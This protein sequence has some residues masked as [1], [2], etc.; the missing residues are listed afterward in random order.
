MRTFYL[1]LIFCLQSISYSVNS[2][3][4]LVVSFDG[5]RYDYIDRNITPNLHMLKSKSTSARFLVNIFPT[6][7]YPNHFSLATGLY[8]EHHGVLASEIYLPEKNLELKYGYDLWHYNDSVMPIWTLNEKA[9]YLSGVMM[10]PGSE[11]E[12]VNTKTTY[13]FKYNLSVPWE[14]RVNTV[15]DWFTDKKKTRKD[16]YDVF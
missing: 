7:T 6:Q 16:D 8:S 14:D 3:R 9:G 15:M 4:L 13:V 12:Y 1:I 5:F 2:S 10:W 11:F